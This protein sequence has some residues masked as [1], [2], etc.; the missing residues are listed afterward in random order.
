MKSFQTYKMTEEHVGL[1]VEAYLKQ[2]L[3]LSGRKIQK[4]TR[5]KGVF[6]NGRPA[7][8]QK[9][10]RL[11]DA[12]RVLILEDADYG[13][14]PEP[15]A[16]TILYEDD[17]LLVLNKP[18]GQLV[19][20]TG[21]TTGGTLA[22]FLAHR[23]QQQGIVSTIRPVHRLDRDT[24][25]C[26]IVAK[27]SNSQHQLERQLADGSLKRVYWALVR[28]LVSPSEGTID[29]PIG[30]HPNL[31]NRRSVNSKGEPAV[32]HYRTLRQFPE[33]SLLELTLDTGR[34]HQIRVHMA[35]LGNPILGDGMYGVRSYR[36]ARQAL[37]ASS[38]TFRQL[39]ENRMVTV[40]APLPADFALAL[41]A[42]AENPVDLGRPLP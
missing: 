10:L 24:S 26:V 1:T 27:D 23:F 31:P 25:G 9:K 30:P 20:P 29:V 41:D 33:A 40:E 11:Q 13:V 22:N 42:L 19:H 14:L 2:V 28:G 6:L 32:T 37:H 34:T 12:L 17:N 15:G 35:Y 4:L 3:Q 38:V 8:L 21:Q 39:K 36:I 5:Q 18:A 16:V 7:Y